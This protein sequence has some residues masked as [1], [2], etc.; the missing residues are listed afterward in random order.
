MN[1]YRLTLCNILAY[2][3]RWMKQNPDLWGLILLNV[4]MP[5]LCASLHAA[6]LPSALS[7]LAPLFALSHLPPLCM[8]HCPFFPHPPTFILRTHNFPPHP[9]CFPAML[10]ISSLSSASLVY[11]GLQSCPYLSCITV[12]ILSYHL[13]KLL[14]GY[15][16]QPLWATTQ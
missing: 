7:Q 8:S 13:G 12:C 10:L 1:L 15:T 2:S 11:S 4:C 16:I 9:R 3:M 5:P 6:H 14:L